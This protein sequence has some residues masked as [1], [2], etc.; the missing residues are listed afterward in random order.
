MLF[1]FLF[2]LQRDQFT[3]L[4]V[5]VLPRCS[6][7]VLDRGESITEGG[8]LVK[9]LHDEFTR[10]TYLDSVTEMFQPSPV[11]PAEKAIREEDDDREKE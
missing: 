6:E 2:L 4:L 11:E 10:S 8:T 7:P 3:Q 9:V 5:S 1:G